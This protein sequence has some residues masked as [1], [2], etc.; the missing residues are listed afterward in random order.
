[1]GLLKIVI[2]PL[3]G[4]ENELL[5]TCQLIT[6][7]TRTKAGCIDA[8]ISLDFNNENCILVEQKWAQRELLDDYFR[9]DHFSALS[10]AMKWLG[11][12]YEVRV[13]DSTAQEGLT[14][15]EKAREP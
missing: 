3:E 1:M 15:I 5:Q 10:G 14:L 7:Q 6:N 9:S 4:K 13:N 8:Q 11:S 12:S 2:H